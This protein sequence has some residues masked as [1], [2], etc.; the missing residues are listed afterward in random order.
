[1]ILNVWIFLGS[2]VLSVLP[3]LCFA[4]AIEPLINVFYPDSALATIF[5]TIII[6]V[7]EAI[8]LNRWV[9]EVSFKISL[10]RSTLINISS[11]LAGSV[12]MF[13]YRLNYQPTGSLNYLESQKFHQ[14][15]LL[16]FMFPMFLLTLAIE[17]PFLMFLYRKEILDNWRIVKI[18]IGINLISYSIILILEV[19]IPLT[20]WAFHIIH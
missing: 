7:F 3:G 15:N 12:V 8:Y 6:I 5:N 14:I 2:L 20:L 10:W 16:S 13:Y 18:S 1:M 17:T 11:S 19:V 9:K 4:D